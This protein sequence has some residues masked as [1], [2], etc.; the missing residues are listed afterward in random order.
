MNQIYHNVPSETAENLVCCSY[1]I[2]SNSIDLKT[3]FK[4]VEGGR[5]LNVLKVNNVSWEILLEMVVKYLK[6][7][8]GGKT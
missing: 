7:T 8:A 5:N 1:T 4:R 3:R 6:T 2:E